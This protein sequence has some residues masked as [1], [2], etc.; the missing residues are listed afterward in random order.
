MNNFQDNL[1]N[2]QLNNDNEIANQNNY[3]N[4]S[5]QELN[6]IPTNNK[7]NITHQ[8][9]E[10]FINKNLDNNNIS[11]NMENQN[12]FINQNPIN[13]TNSKT[14]SI[15]TN[16]FLQN[17]TEDTLLIQRKNKFINDNIDTNN[18]SLNN[19]NVAGEYHNMPKVDYSQEPKVK[20]NMQKKNTVTI[21]SEGKVFL[22]IIAI[23]LIFIFILPTI[24]DLITNISY[25]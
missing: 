22:I 21:T 15:N 13:V 10:S 6:V 14:E 8:F 19:L 18:T 23:L 3:I 16:N 12:I 4:N 11:N 17:D 25:S 24:F 1:N 9:D 2:P 7:D 20:E 5:Q